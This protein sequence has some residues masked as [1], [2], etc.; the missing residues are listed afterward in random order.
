MSLKP[1]NDI[2]EYKKL[3]DLLRNQFEGERTGDQTL[4]AD[5]AKLFKPLI[6]TQKETSK[7]I[8]DK[9]VAGQD[10]TTTA[11]IPFTRELQRR[12]DQVDALAQLP[13]YQQPAIQEPQQIKP[14]IKVDLNIGLSETDISNLQDMGFDQPTEVYEKGLIKDTLDKIKTENRRIG[15]YLGQGPIGKKVT[16]V[17]KEKY[18]SQRDTLTVYREKIEALEGAKQFVTGKGLKSKSKQVD[19][20]LYNNANDLCEKLAVLDAA[21]QAGNTGVDNSI[22]SILDELLRI[23][24]IDKNAYDK[25]FKKIFS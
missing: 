18:K 2:R 5:Q 17:E 13:F 21:K 12:N 25:L 8:Q 16:E 11:L 4:F 15:Q 6:D 14:V 20:I 22:N 24:A 3:K 7:A 23:N 9:I 1:I 19:V 10:A